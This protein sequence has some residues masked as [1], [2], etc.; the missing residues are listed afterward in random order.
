VNRIRKIKSYTNRRVL[1]AASACILAALF[2]PSS[3]FACAACYGQSDSAMAQ[4]MNFGI[5]TLLAVVVAVFGSVAGFF[6]YLARRSSQVKTGDASANF[7]E[8]HE[9]LIYE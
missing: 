4:G 8:P 9:S 1:A 5:L 3:A 2:H 7:P 6:F